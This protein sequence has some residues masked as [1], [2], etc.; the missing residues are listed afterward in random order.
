[1][2]YYNINEYTLL[3]IIAL[4]DAF[5]QNKTIRSGSISIFD[6]TI[7]KPGDRIVEL[8]NILQDGSRLHFVFHNGEKIILTMPS[9]PII[10]DKVI[11][12]RDAV[13]VEWIAKE[14]HLLYKCQNNELNGIAQVGNHNFRINRSSPAFLYYT[15]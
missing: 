14:V 9:D 13:E 15:W 6:D 8:T 12:I 7:G 11:G 3:K 1:M 4:I 2:N 5:R 10:N